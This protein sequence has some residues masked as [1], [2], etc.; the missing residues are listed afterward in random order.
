MILY[1][2]Q[3]ILTKE[4]AQNYKKQ[5]ALKKLTLL[6]KIASQNSPY[7]ESHTAASL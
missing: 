7:A 4:K 1:P 5:V 2:K 6:L 3:G